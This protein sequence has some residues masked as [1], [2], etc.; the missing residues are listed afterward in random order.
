M[1]M[2]RLIE[3]ARP[4][5]TPA[6]APETRLEAL[7]VIAGLAFSDGLRLRL[8]YGG[9]VPLLRGALEECLRL[10][11]C[12]YAYP[13]SGTRAR[14]HT[15]SALPNNSGARVRMPNT[16]HFTHVRTYNRSLWVPVAACGPHECASRA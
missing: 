3:L 16:H 6:D 1:H 11:I 14:T 12:L 15:R 7:Q 5:A 10:P 4:P 2:E 8:H 13:R 9:V